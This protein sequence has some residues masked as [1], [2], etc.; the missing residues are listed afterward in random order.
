MAPRHL[1]PILNSYK[2]YNK[3][4]YRTVLYNSSSD[5]PWTVSSLVPQ[6]NRNVLDFKDQLSG[7]F[8]TLY[9]SFTIL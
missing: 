7:F 3:S 2:M 4:L 6:P 9:N 1:L 5:C 8:Y